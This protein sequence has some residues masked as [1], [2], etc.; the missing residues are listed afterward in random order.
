MAESPPKYAAVRPSQFDG[1]SDQLWEL[2]LYPVPAGEYTLNYRYSKV[3]PPL[4]VENRYPVCGVQHAETLLMSCLAIADERE[5]DVVAGP[6][7][8]RYLQRLASSIHM[9]KRMGVPTDEAT[10]W[11]ADENNG[12]SN[13]ILSLTGHHMGFGQHPSG[14]TAT[15]KEQIKEVVRG[16]LRRVYSPP[17]LPG[18][19]AAHE[20]SFMYPTRTINTIAGAYAYEL[21]ADFGGVDGNITYKPDENTIHTCINRR[22]EANIRA[23]LQNSSVATGRPVYFGIRTKDNV[24]E[25]ATRYEILFYPSPDGAYAIEMPYRVAKAPDDLSVIPGE[26]LYK[27]LFLEACRAQADVFLKR[28]QRPHE[29]LYEERL[30]A[31]IRQDQQLWASQSVGP[32]GNRNS[33]IRGWGDRRIASAE[34]PV[35]YNGQI[36]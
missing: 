28:R 23:M 8:Q 29:A 12:E 10:V 33:T 5:N 32:N 3:P 34:Q 35:T 26:D 36:F 17:P 11:E 1:F 4:S 2:I 20:W 21:P 22:S 7:Y 30:I 14:W 25:G 15:Q 24:G 13:S 31:S 19:T 27:E 9:D 16:A 6:R 18:K